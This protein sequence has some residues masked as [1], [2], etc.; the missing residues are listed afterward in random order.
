M[1]TPRKQHNSLVFLG[2]GIQK[3]KKDMMRESVGKRR[4]CS[5]TQRIKPGTKGKGQSERQMRFCAK[6]GNRGK[7][8]R[9]RER[10]L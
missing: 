3:R 5:G 9:G 8:K 7:K 4:D 10:K 1:I 2:G 6:R